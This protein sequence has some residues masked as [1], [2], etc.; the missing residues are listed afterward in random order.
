MSTTPK[1]DALIASCVNKEFIE[2]LSEIREHLQRIPAPSSYPSEIESRL[3]E[4][5][6]E[7]ATWKQSLDWEQRYNA[8]KRDILKPN[9]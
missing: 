5:C 8:I 7:A 9:P 2:G 6:E 1:L 4:L 3:L